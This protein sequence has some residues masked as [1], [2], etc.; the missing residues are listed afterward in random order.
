[1]TVLIIPGWIVTSPVVLFVCNHSSPGMC[2]I[3]LVGDDVGSCL[4]GGIFDM[5]L[6][7]KLYPFRNMALVLYLCA[8]GTLRVLP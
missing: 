4:V 5:W 8:S 7:M 6:D 3:M 1:M 2:T